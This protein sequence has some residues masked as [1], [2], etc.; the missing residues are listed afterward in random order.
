MIGLENLL[1]WTTT[2]L[3]NPASVFCLQNSWTSEIIADV[4]GAQSWLCHLLDGTICDERAYFRG[5]CPTMWTVE[6]TWIIEISWIQELIYKNEQVGFQLTYPKNCK[7]TENLE[8]ESDF[9]GG[10]KYG[11]CV[12]EVMIIDNYKEDLPLDVYLKNQI[13]LNSK[14][15]SDELSEDYVKTMFNITK[16]ND[17]ETITLSYF[18]FAKTDWGIYLTEDLDENWQYIFRKGKYIVFIS[19]H[20]R[21]S[22]ESPDH[23]TFEQIISSIKF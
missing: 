11:D 20:M 16:I 14:I 23:K 6:T 15:L 4:S 5:E 2:T 7:I 3:A 13:L 18:L 8:E 10:I 9:S 12:I 17:I 22:D 21:N 1:T 19:P